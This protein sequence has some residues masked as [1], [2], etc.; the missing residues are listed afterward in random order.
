MAMLDPVSHQIRDVFA[1]YGCA[2]YCAQVLE[3]TIGIM[4][5]GV[6]AP[7]SPE[8]MS[9]YRH[10]DLMQE[11]LKMT[12]GRLLA[13]LQEQ[14]TPEDI[15]SIEDKLD[16]ALKKRNWLA[17]DYWW[18]R[19]VEFSTFDGRERMLVELEECTQLF[20]GV[21]RALKQIASLFLHSKGVDLQTEMAVLLSTGYT[22]TMPFARKLNKREKLISV[23]KYHRQVGDSIVE[24]PLFELEDHTFWTL[25]EVGLTHGPTEVEPS[26]VTTI[27]EIQRLLPVDINPRPKGAASWSY[28]IELKD[29]YYIWV[30]PANQAWKFAFKWGIKRN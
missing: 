28:T 1:Y 6:Y 12:L 15:G 13:A 17:H 27:P 23:Y 21:S 14:A 11:H 7:V 25:C 30:S 2:M 18:D 8:Q 29:G 10:T 5:S 24:T 3:K 9:K 20:E 26:S 19:A 16:I 4:L 22:P